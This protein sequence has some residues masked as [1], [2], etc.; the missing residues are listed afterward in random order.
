MFSTHTRTTL[1]S[2]ELLPK[3]GARHRYV[4]ELLSLKRPYAWGHNL[5][6]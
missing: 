5:V 1:V 3:E 4:E 6:L 2:S